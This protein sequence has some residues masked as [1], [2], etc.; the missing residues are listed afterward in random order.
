MSNILKPWEFKLSDEVYVVKYNPI[1]F[2]AKDDKESTTE[3]KTD[4]MENPSNIEI[5]QELKSRAEAQ[6]QILFQREQEII[7]KANLRAE[8][9]IYSANNRAKKEKETIVGEA[10]VEADGIRDNAFA[11]GYKEGHEKIENEFRPYV[12]QLSDSLKEV[13]ENQKESLNR[14]EKNIANIALEMASKILKKR[15]QEDDT[16]M[17][18]LVTELLE[19]NKQSEWITVEL[20]KKM[21]NLIDYTEKVLTQKYPQVQVKKSDSP[22]GTCVVDTPNGVIDATIKSQLDNIRETINNTKNQ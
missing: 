15:I 9:I 20:S 12:Q 8:N 5:E 4:D 14:I 21:K 10:M 16:D 17:I 3:G 1:T 11:M 19:E 18:Q 13:K 22:E 6:D 7:S 2:S